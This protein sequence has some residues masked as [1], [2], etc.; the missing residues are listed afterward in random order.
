MQRRIWFPPHLSENTQ[1][2]SLFMLPTL[3][4]SASIAHAIS[5]IYSK[6]GKMISR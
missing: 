1:H 2:F 3:R 5:P 4:T 6:I